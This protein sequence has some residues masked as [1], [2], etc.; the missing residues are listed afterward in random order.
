MME[1]RKIAYPKTYNSSSELVTL[2]LKRG[3]NIPNTHKAEKYLGN[4]GYFRLS[5]YF[6]PLLT[7]PKTEHQYK[8]GATFT[9]VMDMYR[10]DRKLRLL[11][12]N[13][14]EKIEIALRSTIVNTF[15]EF[16]ND[17]FWITDSKYFRNISIFDKTIK[18]I[19]CAISKSKDDFIIH[20]KDKYNNTYPPAWMIAEVVSIG[21][22]CNI[23]KNISDMRVK[24]SIAKKFGLQPSVFESWI[25]S[26]AGLRNICCHHGRL[27]NRQLPIQTMLPKKQD[28]HWLKDD[29]DIKRSYFRLCIIKYLLYTVSPKNTFK[30]KIT[31]LLESYP[32]IDTKALGFQDNWLEQPLW[33]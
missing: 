4:I 31:H 10:F 21:N 14:I 13:E 20:F 7:N 25:M 30:V 2:L 22:I 9:N 18:E 23:Y 27:W 26:I 29:V 8:D 24:K 15:T 11:L 6:Y 32:T 33:K 3:L 16:Y 19:D 12:F 5:A 17:L 28:H 1:Y